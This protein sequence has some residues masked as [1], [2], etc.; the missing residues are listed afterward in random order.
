MPRVELVEHPGRLGAI[1][2]AKRALDQVVEIEQAAVALEAGV[3][4]ENG[5]RDLDER[6]AALDAPRRCAVGRAAR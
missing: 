4:G 5:L 6:E 1:E 2:Q 3:F